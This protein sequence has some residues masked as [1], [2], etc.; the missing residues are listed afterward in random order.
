MTGI[1]THW[2][3]E[4]YVLNEGISFKENNVFR[5]RQMD[6]IFFVWR[7]EGGFRAF[8]V[9]IKKVEEKLMPKEN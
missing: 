2:F 9:V 8:S 3:E 6:N 4:N 5:K 1:Y 7:R